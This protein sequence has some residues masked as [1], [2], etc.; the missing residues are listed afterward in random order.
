VRLLLLAGWRRSLQGVHCVLL[1]LH[2]L[3]G[4][5]SWA[6][7][8]G[9]LQRWLVLLLR[10]AELDSDLSDNCLTTMVLLPF[11]SIQ[12]NAAP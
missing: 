5:Q 1:Q 12:L 6:R 8:A 11:T 3:Q 7:C 9:G 4:E 2:T 10:A